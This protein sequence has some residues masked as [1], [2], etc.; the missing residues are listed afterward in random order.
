MMAASA[1]G[2]EF[3]AL[4]S[5]LAQALF[6]VEGQP[7]SL[8]NYPMHVAIYDGHYPKILLKTGRQ[9]GKSVTVACF[10]I[11]ETIGSPFFKTFYVSP[12]QEQT[13][14]FSH[15]RISKILAYSP[16]LRKHFVGPESI[17]NVLL[18]MLRNGSEMAFTYALDDPDRARGYSADR[19]AFDEVQDILYEPVIPVIEECMSNSNHAYSM[20][21]GTPK[22]MENT[23]EFLWSMSSQTEW[24]IKCDACGKSTFIDSPK[25]LGKEG[26][27]CM[28][29]TC[30][31]YLNPRRGRWIDMKKYGT[32]PNE[33][34]TKGFHISQPIMPENVP[35]A[36]NPSDPEYKKAQVRWN[37]ILDKMETY[38]EVKFANECL[39]VSTSTGARLLTKDILEGLCDPNLVITRLPE[40]NRSSLQGITRTVAGI[41]WSGGGAE[42]KGTEG[43]LK[44]RTVLHIWGDT[45]DGRLRTLF[46]KIFPNG[47]P[48]G[49]ID[50]I[51]ELC[52]AWGVQMACGDAGEGALANA[53]LRDRLGAHRVIQVRYMAL[54]KP[55]EW[56][57]NTMT[58]H[59]D[60]TTLIDNYAMFL[61]HRRAIYA[62][63]PQMKPAIDD[64]LNVYEEV[65]MQGRKVWRHA[66]TQPDDCLHAQLFGWFAWRILMQDMKFY[67]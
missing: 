33:A 45:G 43:L 15:T 39:G 48:T 11:A 35:A 36:W 5:E 19:C 7:L 66:P 53:T 32:E 54:S 29:T 17:D 6:Y 65:T 60:R 28:N 62:N 40:K 42:V 4:R 63:I 67:A 20:Y 44:S 59:A 25:A 12:S 49:W 57:P 8:R 46:Y 61:T 26:P 31:R 16:E 52:N 3:V 64:I 1:K 22:T 24:C 55:V 51:V 58:Y 38:G 34:R 14:K 21:C 41:D 30:G 13:R 27:I 2:E 37:R 23:I 18:R 50:E 9:V 10:M 56:N 47:H